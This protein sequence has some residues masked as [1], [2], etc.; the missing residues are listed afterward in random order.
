MLFEDVTFK[1]EF[2]LWALIFRTVCRRAALVD[3]FGADW[4]TE[5]PA[6]ALKGVAMAMMTETDLELGGALEGTVE[7]FRCLFAPYFHLLGCA[8]KIIKPESQGRQSSPCE[9]IH[10]E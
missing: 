9:S 8:R 5:W 3:V 2:L 1:K 10:G 6:E 7:M 4:F